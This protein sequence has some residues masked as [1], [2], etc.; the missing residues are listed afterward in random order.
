[1]APIIALG[2]AVAE[3]DIERFQRHALDLKGFFLEQLR[4]QNISIL[5]HDGSDQRD[6]LPSVLN[7]SIPGVERFG[8]VAALDQ[9]GFCVSSGSACSAGAEQVSSVL[10]ALGVSDKVAKGALRVSWGPE[11]SKV[12]LKNFVD[13]LARVRHLF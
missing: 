10:K 6:R 2:A 13:A 7:F 5:I 8:L 1:M 12:D 11:T 9:Q 4:A 3:I